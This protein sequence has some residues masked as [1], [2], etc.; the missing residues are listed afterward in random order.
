PVLD[1][2]PPS[3]T[4]IVSA[5]EFHKAL[6]AQRARVGNPS[7]RELS[8][9]AA[10]KG[11]VLPRSTL[12]EA[13][14]RIDRLPPIDLVEAFLSACHVPGPELDAWRSA[15]ARVAYHAQRESEPKNDHWAEKCPY[16]GLS[17]FGADEAEVFYG[18]ERVTADLV[19]AIAK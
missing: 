19:A 3:L 4:A 17:A 6:K 16:Q 9:A 12:A 8:A 1:D 14:I 7:L 2:D 13:L 11:Q 5:P 15:W 18:R 10:E